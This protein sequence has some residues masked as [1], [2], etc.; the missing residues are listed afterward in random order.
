MTKFR[1][2]FTI[3]LVRKKAIFYLLLLFAF[4]VVGLLFF[5]MLSPKLGNN[6]KY[7]DVK[8]KAKK[9]DFTGSATLTTRSDI[10]QVNLCDDRIT[11]PPKKE[12][13]P[14]M[15]KFPEEQFSP[16]YFDWHYYAFGTFDHWEEIPDSEDLYLY[17]NDWLRRVKLKIRILFDPYQLDYPP[18]AMMIDPLV[19][20]KLATELAL[21]DLSKKEGSL[22]L[23]EK[24]RDLKGKL[25][26]LVKKDDIILITFFGYGVIRNGKVDIQKD[27]ARDNHGVL[28]GHHFYLRRYGGVEAIKS[29]LRM[30]NIRFDLKIKKNTN[31]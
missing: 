23:F 16:P 26:S 27:L 11:P 7:K 22:I 4:V 1:V 14:L 20:Y 6:V 17:L 13:F 25:T 2:A 9:D 8:Y 12:S 29:E 30:N 28:L 15:E 5:R 3:L 31:I 21:W 24:D 18:E 10:C 19:K